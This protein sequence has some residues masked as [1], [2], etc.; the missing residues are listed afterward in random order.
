MLFK[1]VGLPC[2]E[3]GA[4]LDLF[5]YKGFWLKVCATVRPTPQQQHPEGSPLR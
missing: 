1:H 2:V 3:V 4:D 5:A